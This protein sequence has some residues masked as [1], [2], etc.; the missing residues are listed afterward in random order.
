MVESKR[1]PGELPVKEEAKEEAKLPEPEEEVKEE[2]KLPEAKGELPA[3]PPR[4][5]ESTTVLKKPRKPRAKKV[6]AKK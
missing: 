4:V 1:K 5:R 6:P 3:P 2:A